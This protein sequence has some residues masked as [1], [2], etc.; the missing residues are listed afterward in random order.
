LAKRQ[1]HAFFDEVAPACWDVLAAAEREL[2]EVR[3]AASRIDR[4]FAQAYSL[5]ECS[6]VS[7]RVNDLA[8]SIAK[9]RAE[10]ESAIERA[11]LN[12]THVFA[13]LENPLLRPLAKALGRSPSATPEESSSNSAAPVDAPLQ[14][15]PPQVALD[16]ED[17]EKAV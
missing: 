8:V 7:S 1:K 3:K 15:L 6:L 17:T 9:F 2:I 14:L 5:H 4:E 10:L 11:Y 13:L 12:D 16:A